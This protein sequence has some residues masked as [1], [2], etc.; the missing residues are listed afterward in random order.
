MAILKS[1]VCHTVVTYR[2]HKLLINKRG[3]ILTG[4]A[5][6]GAAPRHFKP[7]T[8]VFSQWKVIADVP[9]CLPCL[10]INAREE[11]QSQDCLFS[12]SS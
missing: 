1:G 9:P 11:Q 5:H 4:I 7:F 6:R 10:V 3:M 8:V 2:L 12:F